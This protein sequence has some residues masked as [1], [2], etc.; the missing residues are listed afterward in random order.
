M[1][2]MPSYCDRRYRDDTLRC[3]F[4]TAS[5]APGV[6]RH[7]WCREASVAFL[8]VTSFPRRRGAQPA[9]SA[10]LDWYGGT[11]WRRRRAAIRRC[12]ISFSAGAMAA[13]VLWFTCL[14]PGARALARAFTRPTA[15]RLLDAAIAIVM[16]TIAVSL[17]RDINLQ[18]TY[19]KRNPP[20]QTGT[21]R[22]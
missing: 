7:S 9:E 16:W 17:F 15:W 22:R 10:C 2:K 1:H 3:A 21:G 11:A 20:D 19:A 5:V 12:H 6:A 18:R 13:S 14:G 4:S 8:V